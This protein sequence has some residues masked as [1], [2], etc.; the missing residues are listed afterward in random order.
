MSPHS[1]VGDMAP[2]P[3][4]LRLAVVMI[5]PLTER[6]YCTMISGIAPGK[7]CLNRI[8]LSAVFQ[9]QGAA[10]YQSGIGRNTEHHDGNSGIGHAWSQNRHDSDS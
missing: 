6:E 5:E 7:M 2:I 3:R 10:S 8:L 4:K 1:G 9:F